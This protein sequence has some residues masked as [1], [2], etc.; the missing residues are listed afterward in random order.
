DATCRKMGWEVVVRQ[1]LASAEADLVSFLTQTAD[2][3]TVDIIFTVDG[4]GIHEADRVPEAMYQ[5]CEKW[6]PGLSELTRSK[7]FEKTP[8]IGLTRGVAGLRGKTILAN[9]PG[10]PTAVKDAMDVLKPVLRLA[11]DQIKGTAV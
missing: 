1:K 5:V 3:G 8:A 7:A 11:V 6:L 9:L 4:I 10:T 2:S